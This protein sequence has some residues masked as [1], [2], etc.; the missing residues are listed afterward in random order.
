M[1][2]R[3]RG[4]PA[5][6]DLLVPGLPGRAGWGPAMAAVRA[7]VLERLLSRCR[8]GVLPAVGYEQTLCALAGV[9]PPT[10]E[11]PVARIVDGGR[12]GGAG[13]L[14]CAE[15]VSLRPDIWALYLFPLDASQLGPDD[16]R[17]LVALFNGHFAARGWHLRVNDRGAWILEDREPRAAVTTPVGEVAGRDVRPCLARGPGAARLR[18]LMNEAQMLFHDC[19]VNRRRERRG[20]LPVD[21]LWVYGGGGLSA[22]PAPPWDGI[23]ADEP[24]A[25]GIARLARLGSQDLPAAFGGPVRGRILACL[26]DLRGPVAVDDPGAWAAAVVRMEQDWFAPIAAALHSGILAHCRLYDCA[27]QV[28]YLRKADRWRI[29][30]PVVPLHARLGVPKHHKAHP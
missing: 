5:A 4:R 3:G 24:L 17:E 15:P 23:W 13:G 7:P 9:L 30:R 6:L 8:R 19:A 27:G 28:C 22:A 21:G 16:T 25:R 29:W 26:M 14:W 2:T 20:L 1:G 18:A 10:V 11:L 12:L